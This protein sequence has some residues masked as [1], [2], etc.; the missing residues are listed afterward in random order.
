MSS[1]LTVRKRRARVGPAEDAGDAEAVDN[2]LVELSELRVWRDSL[3]KPVEA[4]GAYDLRSHAEKVQLARRLWSGDYLQSMT[5]LREANPT[6]VQ[7]LSAQVASQYDRRAGP[8][9][10]VVKARQVDGMLLCAVRTQSQFTM[11]V[12]S[13]AL[14]VCASRVQPGAARV[15][16]GHARVLPW[17]RCDSHVGRWL[18]HARTRLAPTT[19][20]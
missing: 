4:A 3:L 17:S 16:P 14:C 20:L 7:V 6:L 2:V 18:P 8:D 19:F 13:A 11:P 9:H 1:R 5:M 10:A 15:P 12:V